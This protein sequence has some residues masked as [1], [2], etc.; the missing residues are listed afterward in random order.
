[1]FKV[2]K[3]DAE[4]NLGH[5]FTDTPDAKNT[6][7]NPLNTLKNVL[8]KVKNKISDVK[9]MLSSSNGNPS[10]KVGL[11]KDCED[12][13]QDFCKVN[14]G[15]VSDGKI[16]QSHLHFNKTCWKKYV[17]LIKD[18]EQSKCPILSH[19][20]VFMFIIYRKY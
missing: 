1:M 6:H 7:S 3:F 18:E 19:E 10:N 16:A 14:A 17:F 4:F 11:K 20:E 15:E 2:R 12:R 8:L 9:S 5:S 13:S